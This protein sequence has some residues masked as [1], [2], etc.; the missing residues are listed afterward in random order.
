M[1]TQTYKTEFWQWYFNHEL[2]EFQ[3]VTRRD[4]ILSNCKN[5]FKQDNRYDLTINFINGECTDSDELEYPLSH[6]IAEYKDE[7][8]E[9]VQHKLE[10]D[11][12]RWEERQKERLKNQKFEKD[13]QSLCWT[14]TTSK[15]KTIEITEYDI[16]IHSVIESYDL[17]INEWNRKFECTL[18]WHKRGKQKDKDI[19]LTPKDT[20]SFNNLSE[21]IWDKASIRTKNC[22]MR[23]YVSFGCSLKTI[24][25]RERCASLTI[26]GLLTLKTRPIFWRRMF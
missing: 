10:M 12:A 19:E 6:F 21:A 1:A 22:G 20:H 9:S 5:I 15:G 8:L 4:R 25:N 24:T 13:E 7:P 26:V 18:S 14:K 3:D 16:I 17:K 11:Y 2:S 23:K